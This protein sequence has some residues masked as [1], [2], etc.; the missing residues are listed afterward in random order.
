MSKP[1]VISE[2]SLNMAQLKD[3]LKKIKKRD[4]ELSYRGN[5]TEDYLNQFC[6]LTTKKA[7][8]LREKLI[9]LN[10]PRIK[11]E[12]LNKLIDLLPT[13]EDELKSIVGSYTTLTITKDNQAKIL[14]V[15]SDFN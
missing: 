3:Y 7:E 4:G 15:I 13:T 6:N 10:I 5:K 12:H 14:K 2:E 1:Q 9:G 8:E 11:D